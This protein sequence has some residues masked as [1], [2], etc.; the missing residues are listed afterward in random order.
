MNKSNLPQNKVEKAITILCWLI[1]IV[2]VVYRTYK[3]MW[4]TRS[5]ALVVF[6]LIVFVGKWVKKKRK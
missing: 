2:F 5:V 1:L 6:F 4:N 3:Q